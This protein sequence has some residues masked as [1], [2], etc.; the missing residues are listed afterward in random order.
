V[1]KQ[2]NEAVSRHSKYGGNFFQ[3]SLYRVIFDV[4]SR[5]AAPSPQLANF[6]AYLLKRKEKGS[7]FASG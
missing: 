4:Y 1:E 3:E 5:L 7:V 6:C 2:L